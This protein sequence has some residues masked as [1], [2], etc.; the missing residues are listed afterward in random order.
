MIVVDASALSAFILKEPGWEALSKYLTYSTSVD[1]VVKEVSNAIWKAYKVRNLIGKD[2]AIKLYKILKSMINTNVILEP[3]EVFMDKAFEI[4]L[5][6]GLTVYDS[7]YVALALERKLPL[8]TLDERQ[9]KVAK[10][11]GIEVVML[12]QP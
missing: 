8:L 6:T 10:E 5:E 12:H 11:M 1:H 2:I 9:G 3:E 7:L 4:A